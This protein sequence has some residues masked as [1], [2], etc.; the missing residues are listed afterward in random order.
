MYCSRE[1]AFGHGNSEAAPGRPGAATPNPQKHAQATALQGAAAAAPA[2]L[3]PARAPRSGLCGRLRG[4]GCKRVVQDPS[5]KTPSASP[6]RP[7][8]PGDETWWLDMG[9][10]TVRRD[11]VAPLSGF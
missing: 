8:A 7:R 9:H 10:A 5:Y 1:E 3:G 11:L 2:V 6:V 4:T